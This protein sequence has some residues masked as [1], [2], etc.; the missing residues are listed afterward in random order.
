MVH[1]A[2]TDRHTVA[3]CALVHHMKQ[4]LCELFHVPSY[5]NVP[6]CDELLTETIN[7]ILS[8]S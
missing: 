3:F 7:R 2:C 1:M 5:Y 8:M 6:Y 4:V